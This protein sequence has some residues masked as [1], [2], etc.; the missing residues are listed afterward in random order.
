[1][2]RKY[3]ALLVFLIS[4]WPA[5]SIAYACDITVQPGQSIHAALNGPAVVVC[6]G[7]GVHTTA[8]TINV[9]A[10][11]TLKGAAS[12]RSAV[13]VSSSANRAIT[14]ANNT[15]LNNFTL[16]SSLGRPEYGILTHQSTDQ[17]IWGLDISGFLISVGVNGSQRVHIWDT[18]MSNNG[19]RGD[20]IAQPNVW[21]SNVVDV[22]ILWGSAYGSGELGSGDGEI[23]CYDSS[24]VK[25]FGTYVTRS[26][27][28]AIYFVNCDNSSIEHA[29]IHEPGEWGLDIVSGCDN[30]VADGNYVRGARYGGSVFQA[31][32]S[33]GG[34]FRN[35]QFVNN[36]TARYSSNL[37]VFCNGINHDGSSSS[38]SWQQGNTVDR[39]QLIC[40]RW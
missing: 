21:L 4:I 38:F 17:I 3:A 23:A 34:I 20:G 32:M 27:A 6:L 9:P 28:S 26:G 16:V 15:T 30:F 22:E 1:M 7:S 18:F 37:G 24:R 40:K 19:I 35:N 25:I 11:K 13:T 36:S 33:I 8:S 5:A 29:T 31:A 12:L 39:G 10:G 2:K 14:L